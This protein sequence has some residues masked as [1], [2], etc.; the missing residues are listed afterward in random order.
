MLPSRLKRIAGVLLLAGSLSA[1]VP[2]LATQDPNT[3]PTT[4]QPATAPPAATQAPPAAAPAPVPPAPDPLTCQNGLPF[5]RIDLADY[6][7]V[8]LKYHPLFPMSIADMVH[9]VGLPDIFITTIIP[10]ESGWNPAV[11]NSAG[12][13]GL[14]QHCGKAGLYSQNGYVFKVDA[15]NAWVH[16]LMTK[17]LYNSV[18]LAPW[19][20]S[21]CSLHRRRH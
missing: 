4:T 15:K 9:V 21:K 16:L 12:C 5:H 10:R 8:D 13:I 3:V 20:C 17:Q 18:G 2:A 7:C 1:C 6:V 11:V 19:T 14:T